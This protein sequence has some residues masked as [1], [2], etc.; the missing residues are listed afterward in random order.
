M[1]EKLTPAS[2]YSIAVK[3]RNA[4]GEGPDDSVIVSTHD[5]PERKKLFFLNLRLENNVVLTFRK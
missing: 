3:M 1:F 5:K 4:E 2:N